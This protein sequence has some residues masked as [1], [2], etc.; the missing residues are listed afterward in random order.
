MVRHDTLMKPDR[1]PASGTWEE[2]IEAEA[3]AER[4][5]KP[6]L[7]ARSLVDEVARRPVNSRHG[8]AMPPMRPLTK[9]QAMAWSRLI[10]ERAAL[11]VEEW[12]RSDDPDRSQLVSTAIVSLAHTLLN[13]AGDPSPTEVA[14][15]Q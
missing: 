6:R 9:R 10:A 14:D 3:A 7:F 8:A 12:R 5:E 11:V 13:A 2:W 1:D 4:L 15:G